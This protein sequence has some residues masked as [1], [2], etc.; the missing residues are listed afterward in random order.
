[1]RLLTLLACALLIAAC[2]S[3]GNNSDSQPGGTFD[4]TGG[5]PPPGSPVSFESVAVALVTPVSGG[6]L[7]LSEIASARLTV[8]ARTGADIPVVNGDAACT[9]SLRTALA[10]TLTALTVDQA[11]A[12][13]TLSLGGCVRSY[14]VAQVTRDGLVLRPW[15]LLHDTTLG[16]SSAVACT[17]DAILGPPVVLRVGG[18][19]GAN[20]MEVRIGTVNPNYPRNSAVPVF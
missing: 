18:A 7:C 9:D 12:I 10:S 11:A 13:F 4:N 1:M 14:E 6:P 20:A 17:A 8:L 2:G 15:V 3:A 5:A 19:T 16:A